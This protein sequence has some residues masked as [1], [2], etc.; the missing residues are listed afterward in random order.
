MKKLYEVNFNGNS[1]LIER[2]FAK[3][4]AAAKRN[5][6]KIYDKKVDLITKIYEP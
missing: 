1:K 2:V 6:Y 5:I 4:E 3:D